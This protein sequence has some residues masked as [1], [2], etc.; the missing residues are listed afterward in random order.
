MSLTSRRPRPLDRTIPHLRDTSL[1]VIATEGQCTERQYFSIFTGKSSR[2]QIKVLRTDSGMS[3]PKHILD[4]LRKYRRE[5]ELGPGDALCLVIDKDRWPDQQL[6]NVAKEALRLRFELAVSCPCFEIWLYL[7][8]ADPTPDMETMNSR[9][10]EE[11][12]RKLLHGYD[13][14]NLDVKKFEPSV[15]TAV[16]RAKALDINPDDRWPNRFGT[17]VY[18]VIQAIQERM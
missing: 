14:T 5:F 7:H 8:H 18:R 3:A 17:R 2:V 13:R 12:L 1:V 15:Q 16:N 4:R 9:Q 10:V 11:A 6:R